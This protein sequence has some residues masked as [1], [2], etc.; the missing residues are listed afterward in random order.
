M[1]K[2]HFI[3]YATPDFQKFA[4]VNKETALRIGKFDEATI[5]SPEDLDNNFKIKNNNILSQKGHGYWIWKPYIILKKILE[6]EDDDVLCYNDS[7]FMWFKNIRQFENDILVNQ[8][9]GVY[10][11]KPNDN[12]Y[13]EKDW[14]KMDAYI[15]M[16]VSGNIINQ[17][18]ET[19]QVWAGFILIRKN[20]ETIR[21]ISEWLTYVQDPRISTDIPSIFSKELPGFNQNR[22]DQS[23]L[24]ILC[25]K[26][27]IKMNYFNNTYMLD[28]RNPIDENLVPEHLR[29]NIQRRNMK[30]LF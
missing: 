14:T 20:F 1:V 8:N 12:I 28:M 6:I 26:H 5:Y 10:C 23:V 4:E 18:K 30:R 27:M 11:N 2:H 24:S 16:N 3:T 13:F 29:S 15:L 22:H 25:K 7:K 9:I 17:V 21:F 19:P